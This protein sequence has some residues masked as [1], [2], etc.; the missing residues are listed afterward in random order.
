MGQFSAKN[1]VLFVLFFSGT[2]GTGR[3]DRHVQSGLGF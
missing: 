1:H 2:L 3:V